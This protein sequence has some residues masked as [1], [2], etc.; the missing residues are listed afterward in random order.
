MRALAPQPG[1]WQVRAG[2]QL[3]EGGWLLARSVLLAVATV[4]LIRHRAT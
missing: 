1:A 4:G 2:T 3:F